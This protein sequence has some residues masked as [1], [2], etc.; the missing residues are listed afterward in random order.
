M[1]G[2]LSDPEFVAGLRPISTGLEGQPVP[3]PAVD[4]EGVTPG[5]APIRVALDET[6]GPVLLAF[7][8]TRCDGCETFWN[9]LRA[10]GPLAEF[11]SIEVVVVT[12][13]PPS[14]DA[15]EVERLAA[16]LGSVPIVMSDTA[17]AEYRVSGYPFFV[18]VDPAAR[19]VVG[20]TVAFGMDDVLALVTGGGAG[21]RRP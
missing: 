10:S 9:G 7:L 8:A 2:P 4:L 14:A 15:G 12:K 17:W 16:R 11:R 5:G 20:E 21:D 13:A 6:S 1:S 19:K 18:L 3:W